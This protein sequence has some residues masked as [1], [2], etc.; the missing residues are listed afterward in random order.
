M[1]GYW[2]TSLRYGI[3]PTDRDCL[4]Y[5]SKWVFVLISIG[6]I[7]FLGLLVT[8]H[9]LQLFDELTQLAAKVFLGGTGM[10][11]LSLSLLQVYL[12]ES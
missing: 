9:L 4:P 8:I 1:L 12:V 5:V 6:F 7:I 3:T 2:L 11:L 10:V